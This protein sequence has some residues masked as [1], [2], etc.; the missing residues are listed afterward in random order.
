MPTAPGSPG[1][2]APGSANAS[3]QGRCGLFPIHVRRRM[4][5]GTDPGTLGDATLWP[6]DQRAAGGGHHADSDDRRRTVGNPAMPRE[7]DIRLDNLDGFGGSGDI[8]ACRDRRCRVGTEAISPRISGQLHDGP[9]PRVAAHVPAVR[10][11]AD[12]RN[13]SRSQPGG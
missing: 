7:A 9:R 10:R 11:D 4:G 13:A 8:G 3:A 1:R 12:D 5:L 6:S 2:R